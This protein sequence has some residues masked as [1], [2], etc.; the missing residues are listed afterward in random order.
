MA[1]RRG[2]KPKTLKEKQAELNE[3]LTRIVRIAEVFH[4]IQRNKHTRRLSKL[5]IH[6]FE[7][8]LKRSKDEGEKQTLTMLVN[9][10]MT[11]INKM[12]SFIKED[13]AFINREL[14]EFKL[15][16][17]KNLKSPQ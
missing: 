15:N 14:K 9:D 8:E 2:R 17:K 7:R 13:M 4:N 3:K 5:H 11:T 16:G 1:K 6:K 12:E 10:H